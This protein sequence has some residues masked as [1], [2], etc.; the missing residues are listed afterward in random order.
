MEEDSDAEFETSRDDG[1][2]P[3]ER[4]AAHGGEESA[5]AGTSGVGAD[6]TPRVPGLT[7]GQWGVAA[8]T[9]TGEQYA[10]VTRANPS[11][12]PAG[13]LRQEQV[14]MRRRAQSEFIDTSLAPVEAISAAF[15]PPVPGVAPYYYGTYTSAFMG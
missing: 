5:A 6:F 10:N 8:Y 2:A 11:D 9:G 1:L 4:S 3:G 12:A 7:R 13:V 14:E 15:Q